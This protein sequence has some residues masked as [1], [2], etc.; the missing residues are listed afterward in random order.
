[1]MERLVRVC[2]E[3]QPREKEENSL[4]AHICSIFDQYILFTNYS[5]QKQRN[6]W[7]FIAVITAWQV[8]VKYFTCCY[9]PLAHPAPLGSETFW[10]RRKISLL[11]V[12]FFALLQKQNSLHLSFLLCF[13]PIVPCRQYW[14]EMLMACVGAVSLFVNWLCAKHLFSV[15]LHLFVHI[16]CFQ[17]CSAEERKVSKPQQ[18]CRVSWLS[19]CPQPHVCSSFQIIKRKWWATELS[20]LFELKSAVHW[21][22]E[23]LCVCRSVSSVFAFLHCSVEL[24]SPYSQ[25]SILSGLLTVFFWAQPYDG[26]NMSG[27]W[28]RAL[29]NSIPRVKTGL[30]N[31]RNIPCI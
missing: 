16:H 19:Q 10:I 13:S 25:C 14:G 15:Q 2:S 21:H 7:S 28:Q 20:V 17:W 18:V 4:H 8:W 3:T 23:S 31:R 5:S 26:I 9:A 30:L 12:N 6:S 27:R 24:W 22:L 1:M 11:G 29:F